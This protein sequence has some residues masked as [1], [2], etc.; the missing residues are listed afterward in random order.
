[1]KRKFVLPKFSLVAFVVSIILIGLFHIINKLKAMNYYFCLGTLNTELIYFII[2]CVGII[3]ILCS[4]VW[5]M[6]KN[7][8]QKWIS[9]AI[10]VVL[11]LA[12]VWYLGL[13]TFSLTSILDA[14]FAEFDSTDSKHNIVVMEA[15]HLHGGVGHV[16]EK[17]SAFTMKKVGDYSFN[18]VFN[19][20]NKGEFYFVWNNDDFELHYKGNATDEY[21]VLKMEY[22]K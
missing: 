14:K 21:D 15:S 11:T 1:M 6:F 3:L 4:I 20:V 12:T 19:P 13:M 2:L 10:T 9:V 18:H 8:K 16:F 22:L 7:I 5:L 17:T